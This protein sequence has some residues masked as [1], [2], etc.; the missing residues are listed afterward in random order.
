MKV[1]TLVCASLIPGAW[2]KASSNS[3]PQVYPQRSNADSALLEWGHSAVIHAADAVVAEFG[4]QAAEQEFELG[5]EAAPI[6]AKPSQGCEPLR[7]RDDSMSQMVFM[8]RGACDFKTKAKHAVDA[9]AVA[10]VVINHDQTRPDHAFSMTN[11]KASEGEDSESDESWS[12]QIPC[13]MVSWNS[14]QAILED[15]PERLRLYP[16]GG[17]PFI[18]SVSDESPVVFL[19]HNLLEP[20]EIDFLKSAAIDRLRP[21]VA[22]EDDAWVKMRSPPQRSFDTATLYLGMWRSPIHKAIDEKLFNIINFPQEYFA[23]IQINRFTQGGR[24][25]PHYD[26][27]RQPSLYREKVMTVVYCLDDVAETDGGAMTFPK[28]PLEIRPSRGLAI[29]YHN[30]A[31][32]G[33]LDPASLHGIEKLLNGTLWTATQ[34]IY[35]TPLPLASRTVIP[36]VIMLAGGRPPR[37]MDS[38]RKWLMSR[39]GVD[40]G[41]ELFNYSVIAA[42]VMLLGILVAG[43]LYW[44]RISSRKS[45]TNESPRKAPSKTKNS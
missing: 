30:T 42:P 2:S 15:R 13:V 4:I 21:S 25:G 20:P 1:A 29:V 10:L 24:H 36:L 32:D 17:R 11:P 26:S 6:F 22:E 28:V 39:A 31:E 3:K 8:F 43:L 5:L 33:G 45:S 14:G 34:Q 38:Y 40:K 19:I 37:W 44:L 16:G 27:D 12:P 7:N 18:E 41:F 35:S 23:D 9:G